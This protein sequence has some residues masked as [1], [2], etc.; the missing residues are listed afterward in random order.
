MAGQEFRPRSFC[1]QARARLFFLPARESPNKSEVIP[2]P[3]GGP[4]SWIVTSSVYPSLSLYAPLAQDLLR[5]LSHILWWLT[6]D[7]R[8]G[9]PLDVETNRVVRVSLTL[10]SPEEGKAGSPN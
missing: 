6:C 5:G 2:V 1:P 4:W 8:I 9:A 7:E 10:S 3:H